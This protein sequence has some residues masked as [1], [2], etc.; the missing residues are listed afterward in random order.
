M[1]AIAF[2]DRLEPVEAVDYIAG[3]QRSPV[4]ELDIV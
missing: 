4:M 3:L 1:A 2:A